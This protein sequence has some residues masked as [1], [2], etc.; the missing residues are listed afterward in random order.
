[1][2]ESTKLIYFYDLPI[3]KVTMVKIAEEMKRKT[4][5]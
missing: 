3:E 5:Y 4:G 1:M 2:L